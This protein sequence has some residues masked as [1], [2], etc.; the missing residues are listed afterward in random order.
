MV[1]NQPNIE[2]MKHFLKNINNKENLQPDIEQG[3][4]T[5]KIALAVKESGELGKI[6]KLT[7]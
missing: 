1:L 5:L 3:N 4:K 7:V 6:I 2:K